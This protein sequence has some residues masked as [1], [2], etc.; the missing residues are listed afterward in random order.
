MNG[1]RLF[2]TS[3]A[4]TFLALALVVFG[5]FSVLFV[6]AAFAFEGIALLAAVV[7]VVAAVGERIEAWGRTSAL[8]TG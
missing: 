4:L 2:V 8:V 5:G 6:D 7:G 3:A 1:S